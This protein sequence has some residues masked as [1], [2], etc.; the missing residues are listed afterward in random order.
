MVGS[1]EFKNRKVRKQLSQAAD[2]TTEGLR[3]NLLWRLLQ[4]R[5]LPLA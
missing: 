1:N 5:F 4:C 3:V 2:L